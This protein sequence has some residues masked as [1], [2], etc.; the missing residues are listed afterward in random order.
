VD[1]ADPAPGRFVPDSFSIPRS[2]VGDGFVLQPLGPQHNDSDHAAW[3]GSIDHIRATPGFT[4]D[5]WG[6]DTWPYPMPSEQNLADLQMHEGEFER[7]EAFAYTVLDGDGSDA[8]VVG[9]VYIDPD[10]T[11]LAGA[12]VRCWVRADRAPLDP[13]LAGAVRDW[14]RERWPFTSVRFPGRD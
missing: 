3:S 2:L 6:G 8:Q 14:L 9:C 7:R 5:E 13:V 11:G 12:M 1:A 10:L 4:A